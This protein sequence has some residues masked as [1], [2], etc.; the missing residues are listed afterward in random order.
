MKG[1]DLESERRHGVYPLFQRPTPGG[2]QCVRRPRRVP[3]S[4]EDKVFDKELRLRVLPRSLPPR[5]R[6]VYDFY[7]VS[8]L[9]LPPPSRYLQELRGVR[10]GRG[11]S[12]P[13]DR[14]CRR[15]GARGGCRV[16]SRR[17]AWDAS[18]RLCAL[19]L[20]N[21]E[22][23]PADETKTDYPYPTLPDS[24]PGLRGPPVDS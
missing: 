13:R 21:S 5:P 20:P 8:V 15:R 14:A 6:R 3:L 4:P 18:V 23:D 22:S 7:L 10:N 19:S 2:R 16:G 12:D 9:V 11:A 24:T 1:T 17:G